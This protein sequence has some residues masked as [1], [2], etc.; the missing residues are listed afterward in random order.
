[1]SKPPWEPAPPCPPIERGSIR[2]RALVQV[3]KRA[4]MDEDQIEMMLEA[5]NAQ[6]RMKAE[7]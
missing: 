2:H 1:M 3:W 6:I 5:M 7:R 4:G